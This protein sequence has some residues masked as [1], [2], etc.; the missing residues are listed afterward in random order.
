MRPY[1]FRVQKTYPQD[2]ITLA[3]AWFD[4][5]ITLSELRS[6]A[7]FTNNGAH[8]YSFVA[9]RLKEAYQEGIIVRKV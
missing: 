1:H 5:R 8:V 2:E 6:R 4:G 9:T 3:L 7:G